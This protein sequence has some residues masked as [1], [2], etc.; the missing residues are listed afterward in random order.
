MPAIRRINPCLWFDGQAEE[1]ARFYTSVFKSS[2]M[3]K[4]TR[5]G[6]EGHEIHGRPAGSVM[7]VSFEL[8]GQRFTA[9][10]G[11]PDFKFSEAISFEIHCETQEEID[12]YWEKLGAGGD[13]KAQACGWL[14]DRFGLSWQVV[15][16]VMLD[17]FGDD[18]ESPQSQ[19]VMR[20]MLEMKK[21]DIAALQRA[22]AGT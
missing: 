2:K 8:E 16:M 3:G 5:Y 4:I 7:T 13:P 9:L 1:A 20:A 22:Y 12:Y 17:M 15:P 10:N 21:L 14:K 11:G 19:R 6:T 18:P